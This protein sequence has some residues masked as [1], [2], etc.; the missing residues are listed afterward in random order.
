MGGVHCNTRSRKGKGKGKAKGK[1]KKK[2]PVDASDSD[3]E[4]EWECESESEDEEDFDVSDVEDSA[5][6]ARST[7][8]HNPGFMLSPATIRKAKR[9]ARTPEP[10]APPELTAETESLAQRTE[11][12]AVSPPQANTTP[13]YQ[14]VFTSGPLAASRWVSMPLS[15]CKN[16]QE[17]VPLGFRESGIR[18]TLR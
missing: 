6:S 1:G 9:V 4:G 12:I 7:Y 2:Q 18:S 15:P 3:S 5:P 11:R 8:M 13:H 16:A 17:G 14:Y 10:P